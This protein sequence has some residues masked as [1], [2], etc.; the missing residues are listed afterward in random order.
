[1]APRG[2][3]RPARDRD[4][5]ARCPRPLLA[6][7]LLAAASV[8]AAAQDA[9]IR[10]HPDTAEARLAHA[11]FELVRA[12]DTRFE[13]DR[14]Q[15]AML[16]FPG[17]APML[18]KWARAPR[19]G[20]T[21]NNRPRYEL[22]AYRL[23]KLFLEPEEYVVPPTAIRIVP[24]AWYRSEVDPRAPA[25]F[26]D[27]D[28]VLVV[29][30][31]WLWA[32]TGEGVYDEARFERDTAYARHLA[33]MNTFCYLIRHNDANVG[34][35]LRSENDANP[36]V[37]AV[38]NGVAFESQESNRGHE[39]RRMRVD[40]I[41]RETVERLRSLT[42][43][44]LHRELGV[45]VQFE[46]SGGRMTAVEPGPNLDPGDGLRRE[47]GVVQLGLT[48]GEIVDVWDRLQDLLEEV[49]EGE[50]GVF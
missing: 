2:S 13:G 4:P 16:D 31:Y 26:S 43:D 7:A 36:R 40:R 14:T 33:N 10:V 9:N 41:P 23:Q 29:L 28:Q 5:A 22:A 6:A 30:Q 24:L 19:G 3:A 42:L 32:V 15:Q 50:L 21:F 34:N 48:R 11:P 35:F 39:W 44:R 8:P 38:D 37:F 20:G 45:L 18:V 27:L 46:R 1:M 25:T 49:D 17:G 47:D 12:Q